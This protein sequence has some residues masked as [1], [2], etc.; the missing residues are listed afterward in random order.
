MKA[1]RK[2]GGLVTDRDATQETIAQGAVAVDEADRAA[3][4]IDLAEDV[5][6]DPIDDVSPYSSLVVL[7][8][9]FTEAYNAHDLE[10]A[11]SLLTENVELPGLGEDL[12]GFTEAISNCWEARPNAVLTRGHLTNGY[13]TRLAD[14]WDEQP[15]TVLWDLDADDKWG[16]VALLSFDLAES[17]EELGLVELIGDST[18]LEEA[19]AEPPEPDLP[20][21]AR[22]S[23]WAEGADGS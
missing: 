9:A 18:I 1:R 22:W 13:S 2:E 20:E 4:H 12:P 23:E 7:I 21:G 3:L 15:V 10:W 8:D 16:R 11:T 17:E 6:D 19:A 14:I 5:Q